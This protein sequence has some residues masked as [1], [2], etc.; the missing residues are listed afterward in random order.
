MQAL[1]N[2]QGNLASVAKD[3]DLAQRKADKAKIGRGAKAS[4]D[5]DTAAAQWS[6]VAPFTFESLQAADERRCNHLRDVLTQL[7]THEVDQIEKARRAA[8][9]VLNA[10]LNVET[11]DEIKTFAVRS[12]GGRY[13]PERRQSRSQQGPSAPVAVNFLP[14]P[15]PLNRAASSEDIIT[16]RSETCK[17]VPTSIN[18]ANMCSS[19]G[20]EEQIWRPQALWHR[21]APEKH[22]AR[23]I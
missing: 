10:L 12:A 7:E 17:V 20:E 2:S 5:F 3:Y 23:L 19:R 18:I 13:R 6:S 22:T 16:Q 8:E 14:A 1:S 11:A 4:D 15:P 9:G 21:D